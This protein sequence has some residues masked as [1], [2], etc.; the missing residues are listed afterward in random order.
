MSKDGLRPLRS[1]VHLRGASSRLAKLRR[2]LGLSQQQAG[3]LLG[4]HQVTW[5]CIERGQPSAYRR[6]ARKALWM[7]L[8]ARRRWRGDPRWPV[9]WDA[10]RAFLTL[11]AAV[12]AEDLLFARPDRLRDVLQRVLVHALHGFPPV[13]DDMPPDPAVDRLHEALEALEQAVGRFLGAEEDWIMD[14]LAVA[15]AEVPEV[16][17]AWLDRPRPLSGA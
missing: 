2:G 9:V 11:G 12:H 16:E 10:V 3:A 8:Q 7:V 13:V 1:V 17:E 14:M 4:L 15:H 6:G 5:S